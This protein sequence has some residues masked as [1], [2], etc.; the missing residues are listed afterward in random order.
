MD[1]IARVQVLHGF[2]DFLNVVRNNDMGNNDGNGP[3]PDNVRSD[4][5]LHAQRERAVEN[6]SKGSWKTNPNIVFPT[7][8]T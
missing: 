8:V 1:D 5:L 4:D 7:I 6:R 3:N 2:Q